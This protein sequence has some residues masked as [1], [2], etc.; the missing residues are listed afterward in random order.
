MTKNQIPNTKKRQKPNAKA[1]IG[2][3]LRELVPKCDE[4]STSRFRNE[5]GSRFGLAV[6]RD[7]DA[8]LLAQ[9]F[10]P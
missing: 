4:P 9:S 3:H 5:R 1:Q 2:K 10:T 8:Y 6:W 7:L